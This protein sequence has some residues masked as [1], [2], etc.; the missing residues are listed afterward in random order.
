MFEMNWEKWLNLIQK[1][2]SLGF[3]IIQEVKKEQ[4]M[5]FDW[6]PEV[7]E[8]NLLEYLRYLK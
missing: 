1:G 5:R 3:L 7:P 8:E 4:R 2:Y 6:I